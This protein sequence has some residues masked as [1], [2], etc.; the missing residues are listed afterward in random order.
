MNVL[1]G[2]TLK[3]SLLAA[4]VSCG[5]DG[6]NI[7]LAHQNDPGSNGF[8]FGTDRY[9]RSCELLKDPLEAHGFT[10]FSKGAGLRAR[11]GD[12]ELHFATAKTADVAAPS[13]F[14]NRTDSRVWAGQVNAGYGRKAMYTSEYFPTLDGLGED[15]LPSRRI[16]HTV[17]SGDQARGLIAVHVGRLITETP[18]TVVWGEVNRID[19]DGVFVPAAS[20]SIDKGG[21]TYSDQ[22]EPDLGLTV[23]D[24]DTALDG[25][26]AQRNE[27]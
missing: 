5:R 12:L 17:W 6:H 19:L 13:S 7:A 21:S 22:P 10:L 24:R 18:D 26:D 16:I 4:F 3:D 15:D 20:G 8:T 14:D 9:H 27:K 25:L 23:R 2:V 1:S 11:K